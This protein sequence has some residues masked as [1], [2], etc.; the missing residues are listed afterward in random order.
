MRLSKLA[1]LLVIAALAVLPSCAEGTSTTS[2]D[3]DIHLSVGISDEGEGGYGRAFFDVARG[4]GNSAKPIFT[5]VGLGLRTETRDLAGGLRLVSASKPLL[6]EED[7]T[8]ITGKRSH[9]INRANERTYRFEN[10]EG[11]AFD[12]IFRVWDDGVTFRYS[13]ESEAP[14]T[15]L[16]EETVYPIANGVT[17]WMQRYAIDYEGFFPAATDGGGADRGRFPNKW[18]YPALVEAAPETFVLI[19]E[20]GIGRGQSAS[21][22]HNDSDPERFRVVAADEKQTADGLWQSPW[23]VMIVGSLADV[24]QSTLVTDVSEPAKTTDTEW[25]VPG[26]AA[27]IYW[28]HN[29]GS[30]D[31]QLVKEYIDLAAEMGWPYNLIDWEWDVMENGGTIDDALAYSR[32][33]G[34]KPLLWYNSGTSWIGPGAPGPLDRLNE[35][36]RRVAEYARL[37]EM[38]VSGIKIDFFAIDGARMIDYYIDLLEDAAPYRLMINFHGATIPRGW[39]RTYPHLMTTEAVYG[40]EWY[41]N[42]P[43]LTQ[44]AASHNA[45]LP[46]TRNVIGS[47]DYTPGTFSDSQNPH[48]T[49]HGHELALPILFESGLQHMPD[50]PSTYRELPHPVKELLSGLPTA[51]DDTR[52][53]AGYPGREVVLARRKGDVWYIAGVNGMGEARTLTF[54]PDF[55]TE[56]AT[57]TLVRDGETERTFTIEQG[58][59]I[60]DPSAAISVE[61]LPKGGF[62]AVV[63][64][65]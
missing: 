29:H 47:M 41:N 8:M 56:G 22:L 34:V 64:P 57:M 52:L 4:E 27:W 12:V 30:R 45:T 23:R 60:A 18:G 43:R 14:D 13:Y 40:A 28:A 11:Q 19:T 48:I 58:V 20:A 7:Y 36:E 50:R 65:R 63:R 2:P 16:G 5:G 15:I 42:N 24:V 3:G 44:P 59:N 46:F 26:P 33:K 49:S 54:T 6:V 32:E 39:Q 25:I 53:L 31:F 61:C 51:W 17:R 37:R 35:R 9:C 21:A 1:P 62:A 55:A 10:R 38:G